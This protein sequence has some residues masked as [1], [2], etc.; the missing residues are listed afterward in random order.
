MW[1]IQ[2]RLQEHYLT[3]LHNIIGLF[4]FWSNAYAPHKPQTMGTAPLLRGAAHTTPPRLN[5]WAIS[6]C[7]CGSW[8]CVRNDVSLTW[9]MSFSKGFRTFTLCLFEIFISIV[10][11]CS[12]WES[13]VTDK[14]SLLYRYYISSCS[15]NCSS[16]LFSGFIEIVH[17]LSSALSITGIFFIKVNYI[18]MVYLLFNSDILA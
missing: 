8:A 18:T 10:N 5:F 1:Y 6:T 13:F 11:D 16:L 9:G 7:L 14:I 3:K 12:W 15:F 4:S 17:S 2:Q